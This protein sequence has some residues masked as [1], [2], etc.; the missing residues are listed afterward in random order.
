MLNDLS[1]RTVT[2]QPVF[3]EEGIIINQVAAPTVST[4]TPVSTN[5]KCQSAYSIIFNSIPRSVLIPVT[6]VSI[7]GAI[8]YIS[9]KY[10]P[11]WRD[12]LYRKRQPKI[13][14]TVEEE[15]ETVK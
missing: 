6:V 7:I 8:G 14:E 2:N 15:V 5:G 10:C 13:E 9:Y 3:V 11:W 12:R 4:S 1:Q